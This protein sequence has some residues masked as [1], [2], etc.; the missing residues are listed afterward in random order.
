MGQSPQMQAHHQSRWPAI[1]GQPGAKGVGRAA[2][3]RKS[4]VSGL[5]Q[6]RI[7]IER[8]ARGTFFVVQINRQD[9]DIHTDPPSSVVVREGDGVVVIG[10]AAR[11]EALAALFEPRR[12]VG[13]R[14]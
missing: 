5:A 7:A 2:K 10:R 6:I 12:R 3:H 14:G 1:A 13:V 4:A 11:S 9:G 8:Q